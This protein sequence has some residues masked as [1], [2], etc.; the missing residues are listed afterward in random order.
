MKLYVAGGSSERLTVIAPIIDRLRD[1][2]VDI[3]FD[4]TRWE[5]WQRPNDPAVIGEAAKR[6]MRGIV[7]A[8]VV[9]LVVPKDKS[10]GSAGEL[11]MGLVLGKM[12]IV[13]GETGAR[14][15][16]TS[17]CE[18]AFSSHGL[19]LEWVLEMHGRMRVQS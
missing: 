9:W 16:W 14:N 17:M 19:A 13:S 11:C 15:I 10:E 3:T 8:D 4:W 7:E 5:G 12:C 18:V 6:S 2:G 1:A